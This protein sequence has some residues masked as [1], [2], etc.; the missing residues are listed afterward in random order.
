MQMK[1]DYR[2]IKVLR[3]KEES[4]HSLS[5]AKV[6]YGTDGKPVHH[7]PLSISGIA[8]MQEF[9]ENI[10]SVLKAF[11][12]PMIVY[13]PMPFIFQEETELPD[14]GLVDEI[15]ELSKVINK[16]ELHG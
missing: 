16:D 7:L 11:Y 12:K 10:A 15:I 4:R 13:C 6:Y 5:L 3:G 1:N 2:I 8:T 9:I 14:P